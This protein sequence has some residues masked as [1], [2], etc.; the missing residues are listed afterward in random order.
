MYSISYLFIRDQAILG[1]LNLPNG[2]QKPVERHVI[3][4]R[5][6][7]EHA[8]LMT[9]FSPLVMTQE[10]RP[11]PSQVVYAADMLGLDGPKD[12]AEMVLTRDYCRFFPK[13]GE[14]RNVKRIAC[15][16]PKLLVHPPLMELESGAWTMVRVNKRHVVEEASEWGSTATGGKGSML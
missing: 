3:T 5:R 12:V 4:C 6:L 2:R 1:H 8:V 15:A 7:T 11:S 10:H 13:V 9:T 16:A 14:S